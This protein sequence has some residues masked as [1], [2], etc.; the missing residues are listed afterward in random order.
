VDEHSASRTALVTALMRARHTRL[1]P[2]PLIEDLW[3]DRLVPE[4]VRGA[5]REAALSRMSA[6]ERARALASP[7][8]IVDDFLRNLPGYANVILRTR[9]AEDALA[10]AAARG[11]RQYVIIGAG[12]DSFAL[13]RPSFAQDVAVYEID[14]P[15]TQ[16]LKLERLAECGIKAPPST[17]FIGADLGKEDLRGALSRS[18]FRA[19]EGTF[20]SW[21]GVTMYLTRQANLASLSAIARCGSPGSEL[22]FTYH[23]ESAFAPNRSDGFQALSKAVA[24]LGEPFLCGF[25]PATLPQEL[26]HLGLELLED[27]SGPR[28]VRRY[29]RSGIHGLRTTM[30]SHIARARVARSGQR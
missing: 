19:E 7:E 9:Y 14:H 28:L 16:A 8:P 26:L 1:D 4:T 13:R 21:L 5:V 24:S 23:D 29:D 17:Y 12:F 11:V 6:E 10:A 15:A 2:K 20:F 30:T 22:V 3:G 27:L 25:N 18:P